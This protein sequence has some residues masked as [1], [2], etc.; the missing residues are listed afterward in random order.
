MGGTEEERDA[1]FQI[2]SL[3]IGRNKD[4]S[5]KVVQLVPGSLHQGGVGVLVQHLSKSLVSHGHEVTAYTLDKES[6]QH[7]DAEN[8]EGIS[9]KQFTPVIGEPFYVPPRSMMKDI[10]EAEA[11]II[12]VHNL[13]TMLPLYVASSKI[14]LRGVMLLQPHYHQQGQNFL[15]NL[16][17]SAYKRY[18]RKSVLHHY[19]AIVANSKYE[20]RM[21]EEDFPN[22]A[23]KIAL[24]PEEY[25]M[26]VP[27][28]VEWKPSSNPRKLA[29]IGALT[30]YKN[31]DVLIR[32]FKILTSEQKNLE[33]VIVGDGSERKRLERL[34]EEL[35]VRDRMVLKA[36]LT[37]EE[38]WREYSA[39]S[40]V[41]LLSPLESFSRVAH[42]AMAIGAPLVLYSRGALGELVN[43]GA[44]HGVNTLS[45]NEVARV[46]SEAM[47]TSRNMPKQIPASD[48]EAYAVKMLELYDTLRERSG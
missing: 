8:E 29:Y 17:F 42:E 12:H 1:K 7:D 18:L 15:R 9:V 19:D 33:L 40:A 20:K 28:H 32:A 37:P 16:L 4:I 36:G 43:A 35:E 24:V 21:L 3:R 11:D 13:N 22:V 6:R 25:S 23:R 14:R 38:L 10:A 47:R 45:P 39:A 31:V 26:I 46:T 34:A 2:W 27:P 41:V 5:M 48:G 44:A 30:K